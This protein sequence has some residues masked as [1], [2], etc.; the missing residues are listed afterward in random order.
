MTIIKTHPDNK[1]KSVPLI[2]LDDVKL[3]L[4][5]GA[6]KVN[7][8]KGINLRIHEGDSVRIVGPS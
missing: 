3:D 4:E 6:G 7:I 5:S 1:K 8:L 2:S